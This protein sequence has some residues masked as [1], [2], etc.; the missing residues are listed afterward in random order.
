MTFLFNNIIFPYVSNNIFIF[1]VYT[2]FVFV[3]YIIGSI[4]I[5]KSLSGFLNSKMNNNEYFFK[6]IINVIKNRGMLGWIYIVIILSFLFCVFSYIKGIIQTKILVDI[7]SFARK[8]TI[9][10]L[11]KNLIDKYEEIEE[12]EVSWLVTSSYWSSRNIIRYLFEYAIPFIFTFIIISIYLYTFSRSLFIIT[13]SH[14][15]IL[16]T[17]LVSNINDTVTKCN[18]QEDEWRRNGN[19]VGDKLK[20]LLNIIFDNTIN[21]EI[22]DIISNQ[23]KF[24]YTVSDLFH[25]NEKIVFI[26]NSINYTFIISIIIFIYL[27]LKNKNKNIDT[28]S[29]STII[30]IILI[31]LSILTT[32]IVETLFVSSHY[33]KLNALNDMLSIRNI[34]VCNSIHDFYKITIKNAYFKYNDGKYIINNLNISFEPKKINVLVG[35]SGGG[36]TTLMKLIIKMYNLNSG[37]IFLDDI[38][39]KNIC[40]KDIRDNIYYVNQRTIMFNDSVL[41]NLKYGN[42]VSQEYIIELLKKYD[43]YNYYSKL[44][45]GLDTKAGVNG[46]NLSLGMQKIIMIIRGILK[47]NKNIIIFDEPLTSLDKDTRKKIIKLIINETINKTLIIISHDDEIMPYADKII[48]LS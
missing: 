5:S 6:N 28:T 44:E 48:K 47:P 2:F 18:L 42:D 35:K 33:Y 43:L 19:L 41:Y 3:T 8:E 25:H 45:K 24:N 21:S 32:F 26:S 23:N 7:S 9:D 17:Y 36:K 40:N 14:F 12:S 31:Y 4:G 37:E 29:L 38:N 20:N 46:S 39:I 16:I 22:E 1:I 30:M 11:F 10:H 34:Q 27:N 15:I 13:I